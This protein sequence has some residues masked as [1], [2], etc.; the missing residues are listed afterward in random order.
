MTSE[1]ELMN[2][3]IYLKGALSGTPLDAAEKIAYR[4]GKVD[5]M[6]KV[7][8]AEDRFGVMLKEFLKLN[9]NHKGVIIVYENEETREIVTR[10]KNKGFKFY[11]V[12]SSFLDAG[13]EMKFDL[14]IMNPPFTI[15]NVNNCYWRE[16]IKKAKILIN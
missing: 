15:K 4:V 1:E 10:R 13:D 12:N 8:F 2:R 9:Q 6:L 7:C 5:P 11:V 14:I 3:E 16:F